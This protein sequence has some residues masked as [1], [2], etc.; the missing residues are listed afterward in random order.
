MLVAKKVVLWI[1][2]SHAIKRGSNILTYDGRVMVEKEDFPV[3]E[4]GNSYVLDVPPYHFDN[5]RASYPSATVDIHSIEYHEADGGY[6]LITCISN[7]R[8]YAGLCL[9]FGE[10]KQ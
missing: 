5:T 3:L 2:P 10:T 6:F 7:P 1:F 8:G 9:A 4:V